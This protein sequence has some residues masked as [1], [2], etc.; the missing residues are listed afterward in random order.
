MGS[1]VWAERWIALSAHNLSHRV[2]WCAQFNPTRS[3]GT[4]DD[5][6]GGYNINRNVGRSYYETF[7]GSEGPGHL[8]QGG[9][10][11]GTDGLAGDGTYFHVKLRE[12]REDG[13]DETP[14]LAL[15]QFTFNYRVLEPLRLFVEH[16]LYETIVRLSDDKRGRHGFR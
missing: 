13:R 1:V 8:S 5:V 2:D 15:M 6:H 14:K 7:V 11:F 10:T 3:L 16:R 9:T 12:W 4:S